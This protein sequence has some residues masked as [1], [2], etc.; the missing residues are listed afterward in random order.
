VKEDG[1]ANPVDV[2]MALAKG[3]RLQGAT[4]SR[5]CR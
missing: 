3:A 4:I 5:A 2:T 1:K